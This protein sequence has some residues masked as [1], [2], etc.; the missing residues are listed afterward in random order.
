MVVWRFSIE[1]EMYFFY[2]QNLELGGRDGLDGRMV[3]VYLWKLEM[4][5]LWLGFLLSSFQFMQRTYTRYIFEFI[6]FI[7]QYC[8]NVYRQQRIYIG[9]VIMMMLILFFGNYFSQKFY[10]FLRGLENFL[11]VFG[12][13]FLFEEFNVGE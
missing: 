11:N 8:S 4:Q 2:M 1:V 12:I 13:E 6:F 5:V 3:V 10:V 9:R 7:S